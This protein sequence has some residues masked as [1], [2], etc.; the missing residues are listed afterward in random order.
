[1]NKPNLWDKKIILVSHTTEVYGPAHALINY[2][3]KNVNEFISILHPFSYSSTPNSKCIIFKK[4]K[5][6]K[7]IQIKNLKFSELFSYLQHF[8]LTLYFVLKSRERFDIYIGVDN[9]NAFTGII[10]RKLG[11][12]NRVIFY[13][14]DYTPKRFENPILNFLYHFLERFCVKNSDYI[15]NISEKIAKV[16][17]PYEIEKEKNLVVPV[18]IEL[19]KIKQIQQNKIRK[20]ILVF[21]GHLTKSKGVQLVIEAMKDIVKEVPSAKLEIIGTGPYE[22]K[23]KNIVKAK[24]LDKHIKFLGSM[25]H[26]TLLDYLPSCGIALAPYLDNPDSITYYADPTK[27]KEYLACELPV[28]I[29][30][31]PWIAEEIEKRQMGI[32]INYNRDELVDAVVRLLTESDFF[33]KCKK[34]AIKYASQ[35]NWDHIYNTAFHKSRGI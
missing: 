14:I 4:G 6:E 26:N 22:E 30:R 28:I 5:C 25:D 3:K 34:N 8:I 2:L 7:I 32:A 12:V 24:K 1:M 13:V 21:V 20:N 35:L 11:V 33:E 9:L 31:V 16:W 18:G 29:T 23:L 15:W 17:E 10:I 19:A 27:P